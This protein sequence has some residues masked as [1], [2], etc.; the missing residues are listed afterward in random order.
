MAWNASLWASDFRACELPLP[1]QEEPR[2]AEEDVFLVQAV[3][4]AKIQMDL[5]R[6]AIEMTYYDADFKIAIFVYPSECAGARCQG[7]SNAD[8][9]VMASS[10]CKLPIEFS[11]WF[12]CNAEDCRRSS[13]R[14]VVRNID[15]AQGHFEADKHNVLNFNLFALEDVLVKVKS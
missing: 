6:V 11:D 14:R 15:E 4:S 13:E 9:D 7:R 3:H 2:L 8:A 5:E 12:T 10:P 1:G